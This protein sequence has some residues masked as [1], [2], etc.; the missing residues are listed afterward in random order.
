M[1]HIP[2]IILGGYLGAG[3]TTLINHLLS[4][5]HGRRIAVL[6]ND[7][8]AVN[9]DAALIENADDQTISLTNGCVC[10]S[11]TDDLGSA[12]DAQTGRGDPPEHIVIEA[13]GVAEPA[14]M[15][16]YADGWPGVA[17]DAVV[18]IVDA[19]TIRQRAADRFVGS[20]VKRQVVAADILLLN[21]ADLVEDIGPLMDLL[22]DIGS[23]VAPIT[24]VQG[25]VAPELLLGAGQH[26]LRQD[27]VDQGHVHFATDIWTAG[28]PVDLHL[29]QEVL[30]DLPDSIHR[31]KGFL[32][33][34]D[35]GS[36]VLVQRV[37]RRLT[38]NDTDASGARVD[39]LILIGILSDD[40]EVAVRALSDAFAL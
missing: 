39:Q 20:V 32:T 28:G 29:L 16:L 19:E 35:T 30:D 24:C 33:L 22:G 9:I 1:N 10:C 38:V 3:K 37:G 18:T 2:T 7:F 13:S 17:L 12:L 8:G 23:T 25:R 21:K 31:I 15:A 27:V 6:V 5:D 14:R 4:A 36:R 26:V 40:L 34:A 11:I